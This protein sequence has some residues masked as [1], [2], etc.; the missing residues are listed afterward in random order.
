MA[1][2]PVYSLNIVG[3]TTSPMTANDSYMIA[4]PLDAIDPGT[5][6]VN[7]TITNVI[8]LWDLN[9]SGN[10]PQGGSFVFAWTPTG[11][12][13]PES[14]IPGLGWYPGTTEIAPGSGFFFIPAA[15]ASVTFVGQVKTNATIILPAG[16]TLTAS[17]YP[18]A[19]DLVT[20]GLHGVAGDFVFRFDPVAQAFQGQPISSFGTDYW[21]D[22]N[23]GD[24]GP[25]NGPT[26]NIT[27]AIFYINGNDDYTWTQSFAP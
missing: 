26:L 18:A 20:A 12:A 24:G 17:S 10:D 25:P 6:A 16:S 23:L 1:S 2:T 22:S 5:Q 19:L 15:T 8:S 7:N 21:Y 13:D 9:D 4:N 14:W 3:Y 11:Y 27:E